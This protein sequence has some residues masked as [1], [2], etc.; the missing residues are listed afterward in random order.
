[1]QSVFNVG[2]T[3]PWWMRKLGGPGGDALEP[4]QPNQ[5]YR[6]QDLP[7]VY[8]LDGGIIAARRAA[9]FT[10]RP[11]EPHAFLGADRRAIVTE[12]GQVVD[13]DSPADLAV[14]H[15][16]MQA[17]RPAPRLAIAGKPVGPGQEVYVIAELGVNHDGSAQRAIELTAAAKE[18]GADAIKLQLFDPRLLL[19]AEAVLAEYQQGAADDPMS[20]LAALQLPEDK[21]AHVGEAARRL[22]LGFIV[23]CFSVELAEP[24]ARLGVDAVKIASPDAVNLPM[25]GALAEL[26]KPM[27]ISTGTCTINELSPAVRLCRARSLPTLLMHCVSAYPVG[28]AAADLGRIGRLAD[29]YGLPAGYSDHVMEPAAGALAVAAGACLIEKHLTYDRA[30]RGPDHAASYDPRQF[31]QYVRLIRSAS[32]MMRPPQSDAESD[33]RRVARQSICATRDLPAGHRIERADVTIKRPGTGIPAARL[34]RVVGLRLKRA[35]KADHLLH[36]GDV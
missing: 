2:K 25:L 6:R 14:A 19:S 29:A 5:V 18:A 10:V 35:V 33:V 7:P 8:M 32:A 26:G 9:L 28:E 11:G 12:A 34:E 36:E 24:M 27:L 17:A 15:A 23:T 22:G 13:I 21:I 31:A 1:V 20:M 3:H 30:A 16:T 4:Y